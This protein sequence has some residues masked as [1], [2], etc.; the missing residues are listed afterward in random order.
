[1]ALLA[2]YRDWR[3][4][5]TATVVVAGDHFLRG[6][7]WPQSV[8]GTNIA[9]PWRFAEHA[10]WVVMEDAFLFLS[11]RQGLK[12]MWNVA[13]RQS[14]LELTNQAV[15]VANEVLHAEIEERLKTER[16]LERAKNA[17]EAANHAKSE[18]LANM[19]HELRTPLNAVI[20]FSDVLVEQV[21]GPLN[22]MQDQYVHDI[23]DSGQHLLSLVNDVLDLAKI[24]S[25]TM[26][27]ELSEVDV[28]GLVE[29]T[30]QTFR[31]RAVRS[32][33][34]LLSEIA[35]EIDQIQADER[36]LK[37]LLYNFLGNAIKFTPEGGTITVR[38]RLIEEGC[39]LSV[40]DTGVGIPAVEHAKIFET[41]YQVDSSLAKAK[42]GTGLGLALVRQIAE[43]HGGRV[44]VESEPGK[45]SE[46][47]CLLPSCNATPVSPARDAACHT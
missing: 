24:E 12:E 17:A 45:G 14:R 4:L 19:S 18:F 33:V 20:G 40:A 29:R 21:C 38:A 1:L 3:V 37:Q 16:E 46:F 30:V 5:L 35:L 27:F 10:G 7:L 9:S 8:Y 31:E 23:L 2:F 41:F 34:R 43:M 15:T 28:R 22:E 6:L 36:R 13:E 25:G 39:L 44:W 42:Q 11:C 26:D 32:G 47:F